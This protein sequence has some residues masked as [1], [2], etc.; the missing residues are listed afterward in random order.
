MYR[1]VLFTL[2]SVSPALTSQMT[3][4]VRHHHHHHQDMMRRRNDDNDNES[5]LSTPPLPITDRQQFIK[6]EP[7]SPSASAA[8]HPR[9]VTSVPA[10]RQGQGQTQGQW[11]EEEDAVLTSCR[12]VGAEALFN[13]SQGRDCAGG[14]TQGHGREAAVTSL[15]GDDTS[16]TSSTS[17][18]TTTT[19]T[20]SLTSLACSSEAFDSDLS[21]DT[22][23]VI[24]KHAR[25][26]LST[27]QPLD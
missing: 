19:S 23:T 5:S 14:Q 20:S 3:S 22:S 10:C 9:H 7:L 21:M 2:N 6:A 15:L 11:R 26:D 24:A 27:W 25:L 13:V 16:C 18:T 17:T 4:P 8:A 12:C 1:Q